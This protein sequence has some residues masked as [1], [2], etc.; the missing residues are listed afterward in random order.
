MKLMISGILVLAA[1]GAAA[2]PLHFV[3]E[4]RERLPFAVVG[5][6][7][8]DVAL[9]DLDG[10]GD[11]D[12]AVAS[13]FGQNYVLTNDGAGRF[14]LDPGALPQGRVHDSE[15]IAAADFDRDG[16]VDLVFVAEDD[17]VNEH[18]T[19]PA[20]ARID[21][22]DAF[23]VRGTSNGVTF[24]DLDGDDDVDLIVGNAGPNFW[25]ENVGGTFRDATRG[26]LPASERVTQDVEL[27]DVDGDG[28]LDLIAG[29][30]DGNE[31]LVNQGTGV[32][33]DASEQLPAPAWTEE[34]READFAD[35]DGDGDADLYFANVGWRDGAV[36][37]DRLLLNDGTG[38]FSD[39]TDRLPDEEMFTLDAD[40]RDLDRDGDL[41]LV[42]ADLGGGG[43]RIRENDGTGR[44]TDVTAEVLPEGFGGPAIDV[45]VGDVTGDGVPD[46][47][48]GMHMGPDRLLVGVP[49]G[50]ES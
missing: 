8:M 21:R 42:L 9:L 23:P 12:V 34:T 18:Y 28:D 6:R 22:T 32:F 17:E 10:D 47:Y 35:V 44:F 30:E 29:N 36:A 19:G 46:L 26:R 14:A 43:V 50:G 15:D 11:L 3:D 45:E 20:N 41:D 16:T 39:A 49:A 1:T 4:S 7:S 48:V 2:F 33:V 24:A 40:F 5:S 27:A 37:R 25:L 31:L 13:E 38:R